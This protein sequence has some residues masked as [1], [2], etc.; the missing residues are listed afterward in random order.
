MFRTL[1]K[2]HSHSKWIYIN[3]EAD[4]WRWKEKESKGDEATKDWGK[5]KWERKDREPLQ[6]IKRTRCDARGVRE[7][8][9][10]W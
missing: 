3:K 9:V 4:T 5:R 8:D 6:W 2:L 10:K 1:D 7:K